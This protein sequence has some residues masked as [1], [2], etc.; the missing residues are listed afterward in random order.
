MFWSIWCNE[1]WVGLERGPVGHLPRRLHA[2]PVGSRSLCA[3]DGPRRARS[4]LPAALEVRCSPSTRR[5]RPQRPDRAPEWPHGRVPTAPRASP[6]TRTIAGRLLPTCRGRLARRA[7]GS[8]CGAWARSGRPPSCS[9]SSAASRWNA[10]P[11]GARAGR[12]SPS[13]RRPDADDAGHA[14]ATNGAAVRPTASTSPGVPARA[15]RAAP[16]PLERQ[17]DDAAVRRLGLLLERPSA[18]D[19]TAEHRAPVVDHGQPDDPPGGAVEATPLTRSATATTS[20]V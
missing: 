13:E 6:A 5:R 17:H 15:C 19:P 11:G 20:A 16:T 3:G 12:P 18:S 7:P 2:R 10:G 4:N 8:T 1:R 9:A 14:C